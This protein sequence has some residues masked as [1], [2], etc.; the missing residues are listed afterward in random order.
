[1][2]PHDV[3]DAHSNLITVA[4]TSAQLAERHASIHAHSRVGAAASLFCDALGNLQCSNTT[5]RVLQV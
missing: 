4:T 3:Q 1:V 2:V 5:E